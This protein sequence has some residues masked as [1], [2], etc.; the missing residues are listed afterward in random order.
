MLCVFRNGA[1]LLDGEGDGIWKFPGPP[2]SAL[3]RLELLCA[4][5]SQSLDAQLG[6]DRFSRA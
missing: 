3:M 1:D 6:F 4:S 2:N 5:C